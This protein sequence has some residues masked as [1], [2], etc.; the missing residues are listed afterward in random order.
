MMFVRIKPDKSSEA[1]GTTN[2]KLT[3]LRH[4]GHCQSLPE[5][6]CQSLSPKKDYDSSQLCMSGRA[7]YPSFFER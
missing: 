6:I 1:S 7:A 2:P 4:R 3:E 5:Q